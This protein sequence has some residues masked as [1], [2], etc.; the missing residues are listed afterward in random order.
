MKTRLVQLHLA[1]TLRVLAVC[2]MWAGVF[3]QAD[4]LRFMHGV[5]SM[6]VPD[7]LWSSVA[8]WYVFNASSGT[9]VFAGRGPVAG[10]TADVNGIADARADIIPL[11]GL[12]LEN[13]TVT[14][15]NF[16]VGTLACALSGSSFVGSM[17][18]VTTQ[19]TVP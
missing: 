5:N 1:L 11:A 15:G 12:E 16:T 2:L 14:N 6:G 19:M 17:I 13:A 8:N 18:E 9:Y 3:A 7:F 10:D 4:T